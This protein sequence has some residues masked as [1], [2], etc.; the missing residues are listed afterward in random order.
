[1]VSSIIVKVSSGFSME[2]AR[3]MGLSVLKV[4]NLFFMQWP[5]SLTYTNNCFVMGDYYYLVWRWF[6]CV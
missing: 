1:M 3:C 6:K 4:L 2:R 5:H